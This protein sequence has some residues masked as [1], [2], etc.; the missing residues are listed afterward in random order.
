M[1]KASREELEAEL[2]LVLRQI[3]EKTRTIDVLNKELDAM[4]GTRNDLANR[5]S[6]MIIKGQS[7]SLGITDH[8]VLRYAQ[9][10][11]G[12]DVMA[13]K[14]E[15][16][17]IL[18]D[19]PPLSTGKFNGFVVEEGVVVT[20]VSKRDPESNKASKEKKLNAVISQ[21]GPIKMEY[22]PLEPAK[23]AD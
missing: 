1:P 18:K 10:K 13:L 5:L 20:F 11:H 19:L 4:A 22:L 8:A 17:G 7:N 23:G 3:E 12:L 9:R 2:N 14:I 16:L 21:M 6:H 15:I